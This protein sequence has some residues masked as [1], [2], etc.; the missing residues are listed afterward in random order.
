M[1]EEGKLLKIVNEIYTDGNS[2]EDRLK[3]RQT[4][5]LSNVLIYFYFQNDGCRK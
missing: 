5:N 3:K 4:S 1:V 2:L